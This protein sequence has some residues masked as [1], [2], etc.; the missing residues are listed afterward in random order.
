M[1]SLWRYKC[2]LCLFYLYIFM[3]WR[4]FV[5]G[6]LFRRRQNE[7][8]TFQVFKEEFMFYLFC[9]FF[10]ECCSLKH[11]K[12]YMKWN[13]VNF[14]HIWKEYF[15]ISRKSKDLPKSKSN[16]HLKELSFY[17][18]KEILV[19]VN[20]RKIEMCEK[21]LSIFRRNVKFSRC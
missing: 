6:N 7:N 4:K 17:S 5:H 2:E 11:Q 8:I 19:S 16:L 20:Q 1:V 12:L 14:I 9:I 10:S 3:A 21:C 15:L 13:R 18:E